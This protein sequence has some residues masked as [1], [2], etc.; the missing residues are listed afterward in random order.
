M[1]QQTQSPLDKPEIRKFVEELAGDPGQS[2]NQIAIAVRQAWGVSTSDTAIRRALKRWN[3]LRPQGFEKPGSKLKGDEGWLISTPTEQLADSEQLMRERGFD[4]EEWEVVDAT[5]NVWE[6]AP[7]KLDQKNGREGNRSYKQ[8]KIRVRKRKHIV[9]LAP[10]GDSY[11]RPLVKSNVMRDG[12]L[13]VFTGDQQAP[14][15]DEDLHAKFVAWLKENKPARGV[16]IGDTVDFPDISRHRLRPEINATV[17]ECINSGYALL[18]DYVEASPTTE[19][20]KLPGNHD[21]RIRNTLIDWTA[22][23]YDIK[24]AEIEGHDEVSV[25]SIEHLLRLERLGIHYIDPG[26]SYEHAQV[27]I[28]PYLAARHG[29]LATKGSGASALKTLEHLGYSI[30]VGHTHRQSLVHRTTHDIGG[31]PTTL[32]AAETGCMCKIQGGLGYAVAPDWQNGFATAEVYPGGK[33]KID[34]GT[35]VS[36][37]LLWRDQRYE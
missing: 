34:L 10:G 4:P 36:N 17:Q 1:S 29:W 7:V 26:N 22:E 25:L 9:L 31:V 30:V 33:F 12:G 15:H 23:L 2:N 8:L 24:R 5:I 27:E 11:E 16:L 13:V 14:Y 35:Y 21:E 28:S 37:M 6:G 20:V 3:V 18:K 32:A 19:W